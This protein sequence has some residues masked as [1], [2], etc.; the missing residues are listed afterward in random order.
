LNKR[1]NS[2]P[3]NPL[4]YSVNDPST[5]TAS[6]GGTIAIT[7]APSLTLKNYMLKTSEAG[8]IVATIAVRLVATK[9]SRLNCFQ[10]SGVINSTALRP[11]ETT[12]QQESCLIIALHINARKKLWQLMREPVAIKY[13]SV[14][15]SMRTYRNRLFSKFC[16]RKISIFNYINNEE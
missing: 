16:F 6:A 4:P 7:L 11:T 3:L 14:G 9:E 10:T 15:T 13:L 12:L 5:L 2:K 1:I 8:S